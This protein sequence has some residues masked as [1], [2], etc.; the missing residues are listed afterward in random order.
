MKWIYFYD[1]ICQYLKEDEK[2]LWSRKET[3]NLFSFIPFGIKIGFC[4]IIFFTLGCIYTGLVLR[5]LIGTL[6]MFSIG[7]FGLVLVVL[8]LVRSYK[9]VTKIQLT[10][11]QLKEYD[12]FYIIT[13]KR[14]I[15]KDYHFHSK[16]NFSKYPKNA[17]Q[18]V[19]DTVFL[20][21]DSVEAIIVDYVFKE[22]NFK[23]K[24]FPEGRAFF[25]DFKEKSEMKKVI[26]KI[27][28]VILLKI[29]EK[30]VVKEDVLYAKYIREE[31]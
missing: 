24:N 7:I 15:R 8:I 27:Q 31:K 1:E 9:E 11:E 21:F 18:K 12:F 23:I 20:H 6:V 3:K 10:H 26:E 4:I 19:G 25:L 22:V 17:F 29:L 13:N 28:T 16:Q 14:Y 30:K 2:I 5:T